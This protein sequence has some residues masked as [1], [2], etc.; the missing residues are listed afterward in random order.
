MIDLLVTGGH[1]LTMDPLRRIFAPGAVAIADGRIVEV[2][3]SEALAA[4]Y[5]AERTMDAAGMAVMPGLIDTH[6][7]AGH[8]LTKTIGE[9]S[10]DR[11]WLDLMDDIYF[12]STTPDFWLAEG[13]LGALERL[14][15][16]TT[17]GIS[18]VG[19]QPRCDDPVYA[20]KSAEGYRDVGVRGIVCVG[21]ARAP[22]PRVMATWENGKRV[23]HEVSLEQ[24]F[25]T[26]EQVIQEWNGAANGRIRVYVMAAVLVPSSEPGRPVA[27]D[28]VQPID[29]AQAEGVRRLANT[30]QTG[31]HF[32]CYGDMIRRAYQARL[33]VLGPDVSLAHC[34]GI[35]EQ[36]IEI[37][38]ETGTSVCHGPTTRSYVRARCP[39][40]ELIEAGVT[41]GLAT[42]GTAPDR[43]F[44]L[45]AQF[46]MAMMLQRVHFQDPSYMPP[47][48]VLEMATVD[49]AKA[50]N[51]QDE[52]GSLESGKRADLILVNLRQPH[53]TPTFMVPQRLAYEATGHDVHTVIVDGQV[54]MEDRR[55]LTIDERQVL[56]DAEREAEL[57][58][59]RAG[60]QDRLGLPDRF[61]G[62]ARY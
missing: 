35:G 26:T 24:A 30:Y 50:L 34:T 62:H 57:M 19:S 58:V 16:G 33:D 14:K 52:I 45:F 46:K 54:L 48:K 13:R 38:R 2:G 12:L 42:D 21:P 4:R 56:R 36:D 28:D 15:F 5:Q 6:G 10:N 1:V 59:Q 20:G 39:V 43:S 51:L 40:P 32:H 9:R 44:D 41:V 27:A 55:V 37:L 25:R 23:E 8:G 31:I 3:P 22:W 7:H 47:G 18:I 60:L 49:A 61:W 29:R 11:G 17:C 53:L